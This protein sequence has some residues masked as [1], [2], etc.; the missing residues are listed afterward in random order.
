[1]E[2]L[3]KRI[4]SEYNDIYTNPV[5]TI[6]VSPETMNHL[7]LTGKKTIDSIKHYFDDI[8]IAISRKI[9]QD[10]IIISSNSLD[11]FERNQLVKSE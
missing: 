10:K 11:E 6:I 9:K 7:L 1:M 8:R 4:I 2:N 5:K 3:I